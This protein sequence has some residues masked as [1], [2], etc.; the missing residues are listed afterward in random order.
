[1]AG[2]R[3]IHTIAEVVALQPVRIRFASGGT[4][5]T[6]S[7]RRRASHRIP[8]DTADLKDDVQES[9]RLAPVAEVS[10]RESN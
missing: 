10:G 8:R 2:V 5:A 9:K 1:M 6:G 4:R 3:E 7:E